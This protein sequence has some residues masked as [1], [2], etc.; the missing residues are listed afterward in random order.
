ML[1]VIIS[2]L[3]DICGFYMCKTC[4][5]CIIV[6]YKNVALAGEL[7]EVTMNFTGDLMIKNYV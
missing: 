2:G 6:G 1:Y 7:L 3:F 4:L 5:N